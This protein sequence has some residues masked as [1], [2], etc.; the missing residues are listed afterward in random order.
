MIKQISLKALKNKK[1][2]YDKNS[3]KDK[4]SKQKKRDKTS[5]LFIYYNET[6]S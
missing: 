2:A 1:R 3:N 5:R 6:T 4:L